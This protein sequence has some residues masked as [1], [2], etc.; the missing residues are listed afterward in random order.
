M[1]AMP[2]LS[3]RA[4]PLGGVIV[5]KVA[6][7][8]NVTT[9]SGTA[10]PVL[11]NTV[12]VTVVAA[13]EVIEF[14]AAPAALERPTFIDPPVDVVVVPFVFDV[15]A[16]LAPQPDNSAAAAANIKTVKNFA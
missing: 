10:K 6:F 3:V 5:A 1:L 16:P 12:A 11:S 9:V 13:A 15:A 7:V 4:V 8:E 14:T 2:L